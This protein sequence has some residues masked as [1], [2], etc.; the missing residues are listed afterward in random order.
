MRRRKFALAGALVIVTCA[1]LF[2]QTL[3]ARRYLT[4]PKEIIEAFDAPPLPAAILSPSKQVIALTYRRA[5]PTI[6]E[7]SR[8][9]LRLAGERVNPKTNG[10][11]RTGLIYA[12]A[13]KKIADGSE[14]KVTVPP[15]AN[16]SNVRFS[17]DGAHLSFL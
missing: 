10:P 14:V 9:M 11:H 8:P 7:L 12:I 1:A 13:L 4:P 6:A 17:P 16:L 5:Y 2:G 3:D 15:Q